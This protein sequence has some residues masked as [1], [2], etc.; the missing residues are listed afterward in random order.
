MLKLLAEIDRR[1]RVLSRVGWLNVALLTAM[2][3][4]ATF[5]SRQ[6]L[7]LNVWIKPIK[8]AASITI[9]V[10]TLAWFM[11][12]LRGPAWC[13]GLIRWGVAVAMTVEIACIAGQ[14]LRGVPSHFNGATAFDAAV[15]SAM[16]LF[17]LFNSVLE[18]LVLVLLLRPYPELPPAYLL[19]I[20]LGLVMALLSAGIGL[21]MIAHGAHTV[22]IP[23]GGAGLPLVNWSTQAGDL[24]VAHALGLHALQLLP[25]AGYALSRLG[26][27]RMSVALTAVLAVAYFLV[28]GWTYVAAI[29]GRPL[30]AASA[31]IP[32][33]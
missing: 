24:R 33:P 20:R 21:L 19:G 31:E 22:G 16:G 14:S 3:V 18:A 7:G 6:V 5:D 23:D 11:Q 17:I 28:A 1:D 25:L 10:W 2:L 8:F 15:F 27:R 9:Y 32:R 29:E 4:A 12:Y 30:V 13:K 26:G